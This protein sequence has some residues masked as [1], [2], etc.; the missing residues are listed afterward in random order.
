MCG[1]GCI[2]ETNRNAHGD[3]YA[4]NKVYVCDRSPFSSLVY[5]NRDMHGLTKLM[6]DKLMSEHLSKYDISIK[7]VLVEASADVIFDRIKRRI[8]IETWRTTFNE[9]SRNWMDTVLDDYK[10]KKESGL[11][12]YSVQNNSLDSDFG[13][14]LDYL[15]N[16]VIPSCRKKNGIRMKYESLFDKNKSP[17]SVLNTI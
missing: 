17:T 6:I 3:F 8:S 1:I 15:Q 9:G 12:N 4:V 14:I 11:F 7:T 13:P 10:T 2:D 16:D 5:G